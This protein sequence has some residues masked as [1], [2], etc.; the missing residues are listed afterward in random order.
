VNAATIVLASK[1]PRRLQLLKEAGWDVHVRPAPLDDGLL[2]PGQSTPRHWT[3][4]LAWLKA[5]AVAQLPDTQAGELVLGAD[6]VCVVDNAIIGQPK[7]R[8]QA[9]SML[10]AMRNRTH[11]VWTGMCLLGVGG[12]RR[13]GAAVAHVHL[14]DLD[15]RAIETYLDSGQWQG[16]AGAYNLNDR[17]EAQWPLR[18]EGEPETVMGLSLLLFERLLQEVAP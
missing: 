8:A 16:K 15:D 1:S 10:R 12:R 17:I 14:G 6:T 7:D 4:A 9:R 5:R 13:M 18:C 3:M 2:K 11:Q